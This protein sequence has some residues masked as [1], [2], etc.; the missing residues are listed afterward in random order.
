MSE[1]ENI[2]ISL[3]DRPDLEVYVEDI[4]RTDTLR[5]ERAFKNVEE[6]RKYRKIHAF[7]M[8]VQR[9]ISITNMCIHVVQTICIAI[10][11]L[12]L[13]SVLK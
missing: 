2:T 8:S 4:I 12:V 11:I 10:G 9:K 1:K 6:D 13:A 5:A 7:E 3:T